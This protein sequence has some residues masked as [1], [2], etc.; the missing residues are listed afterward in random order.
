MDEGEFRH[1]LKNMAAYDEAVRVARM[2]ETVW[3][4][5]P[6][7]KRESQRIAFVSDLGPMWESAN[8]EED[9]PVN[10]CVVHDR[11]DDEYYMFVTTDTEKTA[12]QIIP[13]YE[14]RP[15]IEEDYR[16]LKD[17]WCLDDFKSTKLTLI[18]FHIVSR[19]AAGLFVVS[20]VCRYRG[21]K[22]VCGKIFAGHPEKL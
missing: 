8:P 6:D 14:M 10:G 2:P 16:Q 15:G 19:N 5:H 3:Q 4:K 9:V 20:I 21:R 18:T 1:L 12:R 22:G 17:F 11:K 13:A 7:R